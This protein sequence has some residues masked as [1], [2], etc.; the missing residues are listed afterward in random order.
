MEILLTNDDGVYAPGLAAL[1]SELA[2]L[3]N[4]S[5][6][7][8]ATEQSGVGHSITFLEP[9]VCK[10]IFHGDEL[11]GIAVEGSPA[12]CVKLAVAEL[13]GRPVDLVVSGINGGLNA[14][15]NVLY[16]GT[17]AAAIEGAFFR[18]NSF[19]VSLEYDPHADFETAAKIAVPLIQ[20]ILEKKDSPPRLYNINI[21][22][23]AVEQFR[24]GQTPRVAV[25]PM[26]VE[27]YG[28]HF[29]R[30]KDPKGRDYYW[31]TNDPPPQPTDHPTDLTRVAEGY[32]TIT[33]LMFDL[34]DVPV[35]KAME[36]WQFSLEPPGCDGS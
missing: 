16:S 6:I 34:T 13:I 1:R 4:V 29:I 32:V 8:P 36:D 12:D 19:A 21:P 14:G 7:A 2:S 26:G 28:E 17:V 3:G 10:E 18:I 20:K 24:G 11:Y 35:L 30:R 15:I 22:T 27:R 23:A 9:L 33:P 25:V 31:A 5:L